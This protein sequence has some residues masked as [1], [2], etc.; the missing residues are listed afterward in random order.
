MGPLVVAKQTLVDDYEQYHQL[1][2]LTEY[3]HMER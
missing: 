2:T 1:N 3:A